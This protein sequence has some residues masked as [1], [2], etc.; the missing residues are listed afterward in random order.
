MKISKVSHWFSKWSLAYAHLFILEI[1]LVPLHTELV[2]MRTNFF[3]STFKRVKIVMYGL[4]Y[5]TLC[6]IGFDI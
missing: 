1:Y 6:E 5:Y 4:W 3:L 2:F